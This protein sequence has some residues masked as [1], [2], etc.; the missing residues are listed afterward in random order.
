MVY[1]VAR[2]YFSPS[3]SVSPASIVS[4]IFQIHSLIDSSVT[5]A[6]LPNVTLVTDGIVK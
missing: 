3:T 6:V 1:E 2:G 4:P 5:D